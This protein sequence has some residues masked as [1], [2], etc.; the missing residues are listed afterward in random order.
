MHCTWL[1]HAEKFIFICLIAT[2]I[3]TITKIRWLNTNIRIWTTYSYSTTINW[4]IWTCFLVFIGYFFIVTIIVTITYLN[5]NKA[6]FP[7]MK[8]LFSYYE[9][10]DYK[11]APENKIIQFKFS[12]PAFTFTLSN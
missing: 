10:F 11:T 12:W 9:Y 5:I 3:V 8:T 1:I 4:Q 6:V 2:I 7:L